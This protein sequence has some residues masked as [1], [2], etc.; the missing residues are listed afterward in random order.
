MTWTPTSP[1]TERDGRRH[2]IYPFPQWVRF[3][4][5]IYEPIANGYRLS[6]DDR[7]GEFQ[8]DLFGERI[9]F[10]PVKAFRKAAAVHPVPITLA[11]S[12]G[13]IR[14]PALQPAAKLKRTTIQGNHFGHIVE[15]DEV[16][17]AI[18]YRV[19][20]TSGVQELPDGSLFVKTIDGVDF[21]CYFRDLAAVGRL[22]KPLPGVLRVDLRAAKIAAIAEG[23]DTINLDPTT[24]SV[25]DDKS[26]WRQGFPTWAAW[27]T[28]RESATASGGLNANNF[29]C[30][31]Q[32]TSPGFYNIVRAWLRQA[33][34]EVP[35]VSA[36][37]FFVTEDVIAFG[38]PSS[39]QMFGCSLAAPIETTSNFG[40]VADIQ[41]DDSFGTTNLGT[42]TLYGDGPVTGKDV[43]KSADI[44]D[45]WNAA[46]GGN[47]DLG[48]A[49]DYDVNDDPPVGIGQADMRTPSETDPPYFQVTEA[50]TANPP[51]A[52]AQYRQ[53]R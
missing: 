6:A 38:F 30:K 21:G 48:F 36:A 11:A 53:R 51:A 31:A 52:L 45:A 20:Y 19:T 9:T 24:V 41:G 7:T 5:R 46:G 23:E 2:R 15:V 25:P 17:D 14:D 8:I 12:V 34:A 16:P 35:A 40:A 26:T 3:D 33:T 28:V 42:F 10:A 32:L 47:L 44:A 39:M 1:T 18:D 43:Y 50:P 37:N 49:H 13:A 27:D 22:S 4:G 29:R